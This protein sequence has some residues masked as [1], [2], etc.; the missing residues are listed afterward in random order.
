[1]E[2]LISMRLLEGTI[3]VHKDEKEILV[4][5]DKNKTMSFSTRV[6]F[7]DWL[8]DNY[9]LTKEDLQCLLNF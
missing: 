6:D 4:E 7:Q 8:L 2:K 3:L 9:I 1:M 5:Y